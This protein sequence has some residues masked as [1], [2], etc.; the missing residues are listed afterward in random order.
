MDLKQQP[1]NVLVL[2]VGGNVSQ[3]ILKAL[4]ACSL[5]CRVIGTDLDALQ[6]G[7]YTVDRGYIAPHATAPKFLDWLVS[8]CNQES[9]DIILSGCEPV[10]RVLAPVRELIESATGA[11]CFVCPPEV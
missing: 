11:V 9:I 8:L 4:A 2:A 10:L 1:L 7:L 3:G 5:T 6:M